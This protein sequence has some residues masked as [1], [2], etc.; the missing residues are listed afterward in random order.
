MSDDKSASPRPDA[1]PPDEKL[2]GYSDGD[3]IQFEPQELPRKRGAKPM[4][5]QFEIE[6]ATGE[7][8]E[9]LAHAQTAAIQDVLDW[10]ASRKPGED[11]GECPE[12]PDLSQ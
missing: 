4:T 10:L 3:V 8:G 6:V 5:I 2:A 12:L 11:E 9:I 7:R 1:T